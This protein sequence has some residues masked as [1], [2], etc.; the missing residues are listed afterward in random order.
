LRR[1]R[2]IAIVGPRKNSRAWSKPSRIS[3][4]CP[5]RG[6]QST[7]RFGPQGDTKKDKPNS[8]LS[9]LLGDLHSHKLLFSSD[10]V[11]LAGSAT[12]PFATIILF[13]AGP[14]LVLQRASC[15]SVTRGS[16]NWST[17]PGTLC[18]E[19]L[20]H[21]VRCLRDQLRKQMARSPS[22]AEFARRDWNRLFGAGLTSRAKQ[23]GARD[24]RTGIFATEFTTPDCRGSPGTSWTECSRGLSFGGSRADAAAFWVRGVGNPGL[25]NRG[26]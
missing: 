3:L 22:E 1:E 8:C 14:K 18:S 7:S 13:E 21:V 25:R 16:L 5:T 15:H 9:S 10:C 24:T 11:R 6:V 4:F 23:A 2:A 17:I 12:Q 26:R 20:L 19:P